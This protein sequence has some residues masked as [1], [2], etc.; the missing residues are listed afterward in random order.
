MTETKK[1]SKPESVARQIEELD[2][3]TVERSRADTLRNVIASRGDETVRL[4]Y[5]RQPDGRDTFAG[6]QHWQGDTFEE[7]T[8]V[9]AKLREM[10]KPS[11]A[12]IAAGTDA[13]VLA[14]LAGR[15]IAW[16]N[17]M[18]GASETA[19]LPRGGLHYKVVEAKASRYVSFPDA[20]GGGFRS[21]RLSAI[22]KVV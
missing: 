2:G 19:T 17:S 15:T 13:E 3:W 22:T 16:T 21:V 6:G 12:V 4:S 20:S 10:A 18:T 8:N 1:I 9:S 7:F 5:M 14:A 11:P